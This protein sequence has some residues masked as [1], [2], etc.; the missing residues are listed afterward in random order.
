MRV[1]VCT[2]RFLPLL[3]FSPTFYLIKK[4]APNDARRIFHNNQSIMNFLP[5]YPSILCTVRLDCFPKTFIIPRFIFTSIIRGK[6]HD[7]KAEV[8]I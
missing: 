7:F 3:Y 5:F 4:R 6:V 1:C 2:S 8:E